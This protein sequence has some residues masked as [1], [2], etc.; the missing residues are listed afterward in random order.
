M[1][2]QPQSAVL[3]YRWFWGLVSC[4]AGVSVPTGPFTM[5]SETLE[6]GRLSIYGPPDDSP[7]CDPVIFLSA[8]CQLYTQI[9]SWAQAAWREKMPHGRG[10]VVAAGGAGTNGW[11]EAARI[12]GVSFLVA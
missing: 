12:S 8:M 1:A 9:G 7:S 5:E 4:L 10:Q 2:S 11:R 3:G 6:S